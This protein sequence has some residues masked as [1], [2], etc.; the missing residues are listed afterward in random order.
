MVPLT[1]NEAEY[2]ALIAR[3]E[4]ARR[5]DSEVIEIKCDSQLVVNQDYGISKTKEECMQQYIVKVQALLARF[6]EWSITHIPRE[7]NLETDALANL[8]SSMEMKG[9][10][11][12]TVVQLMHS[13][14]DADSYYEV[15]TTNLVWDWMNEI[16]DYLEHGKFPEDSKA[17]RALR[18]KASR[19][20]F[21]GG[22]LF[23]IP[24]EIACDN[25]LH[26]IGAKI[27]KF[28]E[29]LKIKRI[30][31]LPY[32][33]SANGQAELTNKVIIQNLKKRLEVAKGKWPEELPGVLWTYRTTA[34]SRT[35][36]TLFS[37][38]YGAEALIPVEV[39][40]YL[41]IF[42]GKEEMNNKAMLVKLELLE[43]PRDLAH[44]RM[45][46]PK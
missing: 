19:Y 7:E 16:I 26:F 33:P 32:H 38:V 42:P 2:K 18:A 24:K 41:E 9:S 12:W 46:A 43:E 21:K 5:L 22:Q 39:G 45:T 29:D 25:G 36:E 6:R 17:H 34:K 28:L 20:S 30:T 8:G 31:S 4:L 11:S 37:L 14:L 44:I 27:T 40:A 10:D 23:G 3:L 15:N 1:K 35:G 13:D